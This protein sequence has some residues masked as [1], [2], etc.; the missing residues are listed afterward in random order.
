MT[1]DDRYDVSDLP[2][3]QCEPGSNDQN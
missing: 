3:A 1:P 2:E